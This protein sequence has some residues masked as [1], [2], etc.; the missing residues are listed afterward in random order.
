MAEHMIDQPTNAGIMITGKLYDT[1]KY[2][3][4]VVLPALGVLY[5]TL[6]QIWGLPAGEQVSGTILA[7]DTFLGVILQISASNYERSGAK[8]DGAVNVEVLHDG[9]KIYSLDIN[10]D[11]AA[12]ES[13]AELRLKVN[14]SE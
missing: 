4:Q 3:A 2:L 14:P 12:I 9:G 5:F 10:E 11:P 7:M 8:Y 6:S 1:L 13:M